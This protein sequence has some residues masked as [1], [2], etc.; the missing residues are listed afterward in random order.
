M[1]ELAVSIGIIL[2]PGLLACVICDK[3]AAHS[4]K[5][6]SFKYSVYS[7]IFGVL[8]YASVQF[9]FY[10][11]DWFKS[12][13]DWAL[14]DL[15]VWS[16]VTNQRADIDVWEVFYATLAAPIV[17]IVATYINNYKI[18][19]KLAKKIKA[20]SK[21]G[22]ENLF[23]YY[24]NSNEIDWIYVREPS[25]NHTYQGRVSSWSENDHIQEMVLFDVTVYEY[26]TSKELYS[27][28]T[29]YLAKPTGSFIVEEIPPALL[30]TKN[31]KKTTA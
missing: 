21:F 29:L 28:P 1:N 12:A 23:S 24:L 5:W 17:A 19:N 2:F 22:D 3:I 14:R 25:T 26:E 7:F 10:V 8:C 27:L 11:E 30:E 31:G 20:S 16:I 15:H 9:V 4:P 13:P 18:L 6:G